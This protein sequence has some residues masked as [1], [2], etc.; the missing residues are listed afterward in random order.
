MNHKSYYVTP[1]CEEM[2][3]LWE[4][5]LCVSPGNGESEDVGYEDWVIS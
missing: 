1:E 3:L 2:S 5:V 4:S